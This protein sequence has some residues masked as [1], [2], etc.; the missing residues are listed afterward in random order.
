M[1]TELEELVGF[2]SSP[3]PA[4]TKAAVDI[5]RGLTGSDDGLQSLGNY[6]KILLPSLS[7][8]VAGN[9]ETG[10]EKMQGLYVM[11]LVRS[12]C[13]SSD[14]ASEDPF[15]HVG[16]ILVNISKRE[17]EEAAEAEPERV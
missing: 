13:R 12:F 5:V 9:K 10:D 4:V 1:A 17:A 3:S 8:L 15:E 7:R 14:E 16:S 2:L 11:K 6:S